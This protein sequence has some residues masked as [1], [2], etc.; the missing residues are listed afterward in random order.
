[1]RSAVFGSGLVYRA[2]QNNVFYLPNSVCL[3][4]KM[5]MKKKI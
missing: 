5:K 3:M 1:M 2:P 4:M